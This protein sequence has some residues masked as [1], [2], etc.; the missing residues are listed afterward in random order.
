M[1][2]IT[3]KV[4]LR[5]PSPAT[6]LVYDMTGK[7]IYHQVLPASSEIQTADIDIPISGLYVVKII[8]NDT[9]YEQKVVI[10][11]K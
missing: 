8:T 11:K 10:N 3:V 4:L 9:E 6:I 5:K 1:S 7:R 2:A